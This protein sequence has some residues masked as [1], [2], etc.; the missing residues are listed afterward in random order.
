M[1]EK[2]EFDSQRFTIN[3]P[4]AVLIF[5]PATNAEKRKKFMENLKINGNFEAFKKKKAEHEKARR[6]RLKNSVAKLTVSKQNQLLRNS[7]LK[8]RERVRKCRAKKK[9]STDSS[10]SIIHPN[11]VTDDTNDKNV[12]KSMHTPL[13]FHHS[14]KTYSALAKAATKTRKT[15]PASPTKRTAVIAKLVY[16]LDEANQLVI[17]NNRTIMKRGGNK[18]LSADLI[19]KIQ[20]FYQR[21]DISR[22]SP[23]VKD[24][25]Y[26]VNS[27]TG[28]REL[29]Q[30]RHL[31]VTLKQAYDLFGKENSGNLKC[32]VDA[33]AEY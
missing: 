26:F 2:H 21:D 7:R 5:Q 8:C 15:L 25:R 19:E 31:L 22:T 4:K 27:V 1:I 10:H 16:S 24:T 3:S 11:E 28:K 13:Q 9:G 23:N 14:Y 18:G 12:M 6:Q 32:I 20:L 30:I 29:Q 17:F 33:E